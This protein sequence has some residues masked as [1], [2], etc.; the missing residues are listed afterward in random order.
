[1][2]DAAATPAI[3]APASKQEIPPS[4]NDEQEDQ[5]AAPEQAE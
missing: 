1:M 3:A 4:E 5:T 2:Q